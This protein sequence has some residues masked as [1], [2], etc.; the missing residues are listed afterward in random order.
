MEGLFAFSIGSSFVGWGR[1][2]VALG[3]GL[4]REPN[5]ERSPALATDVEVA[6]ELLDQRR[7]ELQAEGARVANIDVGR[8][9]DSVVAHHEQQV[10]A[11][12]F[13]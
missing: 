9:A 2:V 13:A 5:S 3:S 7:D 4:R 6:A 12:G 11:G 8:N 10:L 1:Q